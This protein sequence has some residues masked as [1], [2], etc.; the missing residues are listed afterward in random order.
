[1]KNLNNQFQATDICKILVGKDWDEL[2]P[3][4]T[5][6][7]E[8]KLEEAIKKEEVTM[9]K[10][11]IAASEEI[12]CAKIAH[13]EEANGKVY[14][15]ASNPYEN[16]EVLI[17]D[18]K[19]A[20]ISHPFSNTPSKDVTAEFCRYLR[21]AERLNELNDEGLVQQ[22]AS[23]ITEEAAASLVGCEEAYEGPSITLIL[24]LLEARGFDQKE[25]DPVMR[26]AEDVG[27]QILPYSA[28]EAEVE[29]LFFT[30]GLD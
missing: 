17:W 16:D 27:E 26:V 7:E 29:S 21:E 15:A 12:L 3:V 30:K 9:T 20:E 5:P 18:G 8:K 2:G 28:I 24:S 22:L 25:L 11:I 4:L 10:I 23:F 1:M 6:E 19:R 13:V 14:L